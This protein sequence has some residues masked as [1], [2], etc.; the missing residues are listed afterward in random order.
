MAGES[1]PAAPEARRPI[2]VHER[3]STEQSA[4]SSGA[5]RGDA[6]A[7]CAKAATRARPNASCRRRSRASSSTLGL[8]MLVSRLVTVIAS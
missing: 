1:T 8:H 2:G 4:G 7:G 3:S 5:P 6:E